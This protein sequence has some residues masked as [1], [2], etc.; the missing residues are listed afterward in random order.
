MNELQQ[1]ASK[2]IYL[3]MVYVK[4]WPVCSG[5]NVFEMSRSGKMATPLQ[6]TFRMHFHFFE[7]DLIDFIRNVVIKSLLA[8]RYH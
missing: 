5:V 6:T 3:K 1:F 2:K 8:I 4:W 7:I